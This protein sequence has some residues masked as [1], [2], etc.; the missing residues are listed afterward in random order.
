MLPANVEDSASQ[1]HPQQCAAE[2]VQCVFQIWSNCSLHTLIDDILITIAD[3]VSRNT[4]STP[5]AIGSC[6][7]LSLGSQGMNTSTAMVI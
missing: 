1:Q 3:L 5:A 2:M 6:F 7:T 4:V